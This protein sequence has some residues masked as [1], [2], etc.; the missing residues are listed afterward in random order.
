MTTNAPL[1]EFDPEGRAPVLSYNVPE[2]TAYSGKNFIDL[3]VPLDWFASPDREQG[4]Q[5]ASTG[6]G[7]TVVGSGPGGVMTVSAAAAASPDRV[8][9]YRSMSGAVRS[10]SQAATML[11]D[12]NVP[13]GSVGDARDPKVDI[14][15]PSTG[16]QTTQAAATARLVVLGVV[17]MPTSGTLKVR[18][19]GGPWVV[20]TREANSTSTVF[21]WRA[22]IQAG[23]GSVTIEAA[24]FGGGNVILDQMSVAGTVVLTAPSTGAPDAVAPSL[25]IVEPGF[26]ATVGVAQLPARVRIAGTTV[27]TGPSSGIAQVAVS[28]DGGAYAA[29]QSDAANWAQWHGELS[30]ASFGEHEILVRARDN[31]GNESVQSMRLRVAKQAPRRK[32]GRLLLAESLRLS[33]FPGMYGAGRTVSTF[34]LLPGEKVR[35]SIKT[36][37]KTV[38]SENDTTSIFDSFTQESADDFESSI[39]NEQAHKENYDESFKYSV[40]GE[41]QAQWGWGSAKISAG[42]SGGT[43]SAREEAGRNI[44]RSAAKHAAKASAKRDVQVTKTVQT[45]T[46]LTQENEFIREFENINRSRTLNFVFRQLNQE[47]VSLLHLVDVRIGF[48][49]LLEGETQGRYTETALPQ[50]DSFLRRILVLDESKVESVKA[51]ILHQLAQVFD[52][53]GEV[54]QVYLDGPRHDAA[55]AVISGTN[56]LRFDKSLA[57]SLYDPVSGTNEHAVPGVILNA[58]RFVLRTSAVIVDALLGKGEGLDDYARLLQSETA[59]QR[60]LEND[61]LEREVAAEALRESI[62]TTSDAARADIYEKVYEVPAPAVIPD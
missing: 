26:G 47:Y 22:E 11:D 19:R 1:V 53:T 5:Q 8:T 15:S 59:R 18:R 31:A 23:A 34:S 45:S 12:Q 61:R 36:F 9:R 20:A 6:S 51:S 58:E 54:H 40:S 44:M 39:E 48:F 28:A 7:V 13:T 30:F 46:E 27:D 33:T 32:V 37:Q 56:S 17:A 38:T 42:V 60:R 49:E 14:R 52:Y 21:R 55:G 62:V 16:F 50:L 10:R 29:L 4:L 35:L 41:A 25:A 57:T 3:Q 43:N 2:P 24:Y